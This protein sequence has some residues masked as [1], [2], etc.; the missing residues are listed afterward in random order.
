MEFDQLRA[1]IAAIDHGSLLAASRVLGVSRTS[2]RARIDALEEELG[3]A[4]LTRTPKG[5][6]P[7]TA[8]M[9]FTN[10]ARELLERADD[11]T[12]STV[13]QQEG[14]LREIRIRLP[15]GPPPMAAHLLFTMISKAYPQLTVFVDTRADPLLP[16]LPTPDLIIHF[17]EPIAPGQFRT[18][19][20]RRFRLCLMAS[21]SYLDTAGRPQQAEDLAG[22][23]LLEWAHHAHEAGRGLPLCSGGEHAMQPCFSSPDS[24][25]VRSLAENGH[26]IALL[27]EALAG[28]AGG[29]GPP[30][31]L[32]LPNVVGR[33]EVMRALIPNDQIHSAR[34]RAVIAVLRHLGTMFSGPE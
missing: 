28:E 9:S 16:A 3:F 19:V 1:I 8:A 17:G 21:P 31:E 26:G 12:R 20:F 34:T 2:V 14:T 11:L 30:L 32:V 24:Y 4:L 23:K 18:L 15:T 29:P 5:V 10:G 22:H 25:L 13:E 27:P 33:D 6:Y 7:T